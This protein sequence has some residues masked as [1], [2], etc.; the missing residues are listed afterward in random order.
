M[1]TMLL[2]IV[3]NF[4]AIFGKSFIKVY[5]DRLTT[6]FHQEVVIFF[7]IFIIVYGFRLFFNYFFQKMMV[8]LQRRVSKTMLTTFVI[9][10]KNLST[11]EFERFNTGEWLKRQA[12]VLILAT[13]L[14][15]TLPQL[16]FSFLML[17]I[18]IVFLL[19]LNGLI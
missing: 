12:D 9:N 18:S 6:G 10:L 3:V 8:Q 7:L 14:G 11:F 5:F 19:N 4:L 16:L 15:S 17:I 2:S 1:W 13:F